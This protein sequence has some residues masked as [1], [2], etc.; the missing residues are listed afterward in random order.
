[1]TTGTL[2]L[3]PSHISEDL[4]PTSAVQKRITPEHL[5]KTGLKSQISMVIILKVH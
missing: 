5:Q 3:F 4:Q 2:G 1:M